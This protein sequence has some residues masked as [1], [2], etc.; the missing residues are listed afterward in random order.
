MLEPCNR[1]NQA[2]IVHQ[3][4]PSFVLLHLL[5]LINSLIVKEV[6]KVL[7]EEIHSLLQNQQVV[8][9]LLMLRGMHTC[10]VLVLGLTG[11]LTTG[12][13]LLLASGVRDPM[14]LHIKPS[15]CLNR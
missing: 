6:R 7:L 13:I 8:V 5:A 3:S 1:S 12:T 10:S 11:C 2:C 14:H 4:Y 15:C 9:L